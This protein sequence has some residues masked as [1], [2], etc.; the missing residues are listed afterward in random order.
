VEDVRHTARENG[1]DVS[2]LTAQN[3]LSEMERRH[4]AEHGICW[5]TID[6][7]LGDLDEADKLPILGK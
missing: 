3:I 4:D 2:E 7:Y 1:Y 5:V 6:C